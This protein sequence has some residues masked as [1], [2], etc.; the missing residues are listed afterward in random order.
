MLQNPGK[1]MTIYDVAGRGCAFPQA[2]TPVNIQSRFQVTGIWPL[3]RHVFSDEEFVFWYVTDRAADSKEEVPVSTT[4]HVAPVDIF[5]ASANTHDSEI[6]AENVATATVSSELEMGIKPNSNPLLRPFWTKPKE[7]EVFDNRTQTEPSGWTNWTKSELSI[8]GSFHT[9]T[10]MTTLLFWQE[11]SNSGKLQ[12]LAKIATQLLLA[13]PAT[14]AASERVFSVC[15]NILTERHC[16][17]QPETLEK[18]LI[19][20]CKEGKNEN[21]DWHTC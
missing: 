20:S 14:Y 13:I 3:N 2:M 21:F 1:C 6:T 7:P 17:M 8:A 19:W 9:V 12:K 16:R 18:L 15:G 5:G 11:Q 4:P 10:D